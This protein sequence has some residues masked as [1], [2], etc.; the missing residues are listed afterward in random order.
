[1][2]TTSFNPIR[3]TTTLTRSLV[4]ML[5][6]L[7][8]TGLQAQTDT[9]AWAHDTASAP[10]VEPWTPEPAFDDEGPYLFYFGN[11]VII[12]Y[13]DEVAREIG[14]RLGTP[15]PAR[16]INKVGSFYSASNFFSAPANG[17]Y[18]QGYLAANDKIYRSQQAYNDNPDKPLIDPAVF[19][20]YPVE[21]GGAPKVC[22][23]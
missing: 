9:S 22:R 15:G 10:T 2:N 6:L 4:L 19:G 14:N 8:F 21:K 18:M 17:R 5:T 1:M 12:T 7:F 13:D 23:L 16:G 3:K 20:R 11:G